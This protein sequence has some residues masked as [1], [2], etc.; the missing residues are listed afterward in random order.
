MTSSD[1]DDEHEHDENDHD[2]DFEEQVC[3][4]RARQPP[5]IMAEFSG[6]FV[7]RKDGSEDAVEYIEEVEVYVDSVLRVDENK[8]TTTLKVTFRKGLRNS[9]REWYVRAPSA[10][11]TNWDSLKDAFINEHTVVKQDDFMGFYSQAA[12]MKQSKRPIHVYIEDVEHLLHDC[13]TSFTNAF[14]VMIIAGL[15]ESPKKD[16]VEFHLG[17]KDNFTPIDAIN[18]IKRA[19]RSMGAPDPFKKIAKE[20]AAVTQNKVNEKIYDFIVDWQEQTKKTYAQPKTTYPPRRTVE[21]RETGG[22]TGLTCYNCLE[23]GHT[24]IQ[25]SKDPV[26]YQQRAANRE[27]IMGTYTPGEQ[28]KAASAQPTTT[29]RRA[30]LEHIHENIAG[31][32]HLVIPR[33]GKPS[34]EAYVKPVHAEEENK[35]YVCPARRQVHQDDYERSNE[36]YEDMIAKVTTATVTPV[37]AAPQINR[38]S[39]RSAKTQRNTLTSDSTPSTSTTPRVEKNKVKGKA[40]V[41]FVDELDE[42]EARQSPP[43]HHAYVEEVNDNEDE[44]MDDVIEVEPPPPPPVREVY[45]PIFD[46]AVALPPNIQRKIVATQVGD[47]DTTP[48]NMAKDRSRFHVSSVLD[49][50]VQLPLYQLLDRSPQIRTQ[51]ARAMASSKPAKRGGKKT[52]NEAHAAVV[53]PS[54]TNP[55]F[56]A[57]TTLAHDDNDVTCLYIE[58]WIG[59][60]LVGKTMLDTGAIIELA[61]PDLVHK[62]GLETFKMT[63]DWVLQ[64]ADDGCATVTSYTWVPV[65]VAGVCAIVK[66]YILGQGLVYDLLLSRRW[67]KRV[68]AVENHEHDTITIYGR[69]GVPRIVHGTPAKRPEEARLVENQSL[70]DWETELANEELAALAD[71]L[72]GLDFVR[73][74]PNLS[75]KAFDIPSG[76]D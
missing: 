37:V 9:A 14:A 69:D 10:V 67:L 41:S 35:A 7:G 39:L 55:L 44:D 64:M 51:L 59:E 23:P 72:D 65:N 8:R 31:Q 60:N 4:L 34:E 11:K 21:G 5:H 74:S 30:P 73:D 57:I 26:S 17:D 22:I 25:C 54:E 27:K 2:K 18:T 1:S 58:A 52:V 15:D 36:V 42:L 49:T 62:L 46:K 63:E 66:A 28:A 48:I 71:E 43:S 29:D 56:P 75:L 20:E 45:V 50:M 76:K 6:L 19:Y 16:L 33:R 3:L 70:D 40:R 32:V 12:G 53:I 38:S 68:R 24:A 13:P 61:S 47:K